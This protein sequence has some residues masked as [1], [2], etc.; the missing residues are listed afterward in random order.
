MLGIPQGDIIKILVTVLLLS[1]ISFEDTSSL[2]LRVNGET[3]VCVCVCVCVHVHMCLLIMMLMSIEFTV[4][5][6]PSAGLF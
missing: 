2:K 1:N 3:G 6:L 5:F 4:L